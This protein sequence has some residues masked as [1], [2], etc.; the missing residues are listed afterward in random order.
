MVFFFFWD[1]K[2]KGKTKLITC[3]RVWFWRE[4]KREEK[5]FISFFSYSQILPFLKNY[6]MILLISQNPL[7]PFSFPKLKDF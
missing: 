5:G 1:V 2:V 6:L 7:L 3:L 4:K